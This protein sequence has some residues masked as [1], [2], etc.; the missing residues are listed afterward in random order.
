MLLP[1]ERAEALSAADKA[2]LLASI[3]HLPAAAVP[4]ATT[5]PG[6]AGGGGGGGGGRGRPR[7]NG[8]A[9]TNNNIIIGGS[10]ALAPGQRAMSLSDIKLI[11][12]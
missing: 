9:T 6:K 2:A 11:T 3:A 8:S 1:Q 5:M 10:G 7:S 12:M 4:A